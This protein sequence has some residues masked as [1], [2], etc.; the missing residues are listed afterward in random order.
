MTWTPFAFYSEVESVI[1]ETG[2]HIIT[3]SVAAFLLAQTLGVGFTGSINPTGPIGKQLENLL[4]NSPSPMVLFLIAIAAS[5]IGEAVSDKARGYSTEKSGA[6]SLGAHM[7]WLLL[8]IG[9]IGGTD[10]I[11]GFLNFNDPDTVKAFVVMAAAAYTADLV[12]IGAEQ[13]AAASLDMIF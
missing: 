8:T 9:A 3:Q 2:A 1:G 6:K 5:N 10:A 12:Q 11:K 7:V 4:G 13:G